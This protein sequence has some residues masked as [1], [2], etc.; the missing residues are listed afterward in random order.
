VEIESTRAGEVLAL[1]A[2]ADYRES[3]RAFSLSTPVRV[4]EGT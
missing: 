1:F 2:E 3:E 4:D